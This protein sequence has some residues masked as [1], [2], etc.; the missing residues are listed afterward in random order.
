[1]NCSN[2][3]ILIYFVFLNALFSGLMMCRAQSKVSRV[4]PS[5]EIEILD[6]NRDARGNPTVV[7]KNDEF[8][9]PQ[10]DIPPTLIVHRYYYTGDRSFRGPD[11]PGGPCIIVAHHPKTGEKLYLPVQMLPG[12]AQVKYSAKAIEYDYG[13]RAVIVSF[14][15]I[16][17]PIVSYRN[18]KTI[19]NQVIDTF[20]LKQLSDRLNRTSDTI[21]Q[22][23]SKANTAG[24]G[25]LQ[26]SKELFRPLTLPMQNLSRLI[27]GAVALSDPSLSGKIQEEKAL[28]DRDREIQK[29]RCL[30]DGRDIDIPRP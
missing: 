22:V 14:P 29:A 25:I 10:V 19:Q 11:M 2:G 24:N 5:L 18:G 26:G 8:G 6:P 20:K 13:D 15:R 21:G 3:R 27:P 30:N 28:S 16:G 9:N 1:M 4:I 7:L 12:S 17:D 23:S